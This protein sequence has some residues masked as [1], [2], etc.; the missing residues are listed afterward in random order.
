MIVH[1][2]SKQVQ[3][4]LIA[5][6]G[7]LLV[8]LD[9]G[10]FNKI[11]NYP[12]F[13]SEFNL[14]N[15]QLGT[16]VGTLLLGSIFGSLSSSKFAE[17]SEI[18]RKKSIIISSVIF[19]IGIILQ[20]MGALSFYVLVSGRFITGIALG[21]MKSVIPMYLSEVSNPNLRGRL[22]S[23]QQLAIT[24]G[25]LISYIAALY[26]EGSQLH[27]LADWQI[28][29]MCQLLPSS[30]LFVG[31]LSLPRSPRWLVMTG[32]KMEAK[33]ALSNL[34]GHSF[35]FEIEYMQLV[36][37]SLNGSEEVSYYMLW[38]KYRRQM[39][40]GVFVHFFQQMSG[41]NGL[42]YYSSRIYHTMLPEYADQL[43]MVQNVLK[44]VCTIPALFLV[45]KLGRRSLLLFGSLGC[46]ISLFVT[47]TAM[48]LP[49][50]YPGLAVFSIFAFVINFAYSMGPLPW[51]ISSEIF[52]SSI[53]SK[54]MSVCVTVN[55]L[56]NL[57]LSTFSPLLLEYLGPFTFYIFGFNCLAL[58]LWTL[59]VLPETKNLTL[60]EID[61]MM[62][63]KSKI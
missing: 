29:I 4:T 14:N 27:P 7:G 50:K 22:V 43:G 36:E 61:F 37:S 10:S 41:I 17:H 2:L 13:Q 8:G 16:L 15:L 47:A 1:P 12:S 63:R 11:Q 21:I 6:I 35:D 42:M 20:A 38:H 23:C 52:N 5:T 30:L 9:I 24:F 59:W 32:R 40:V 56:S 33:E 18:G 48:I 54:A 57:C 60:E 19:I 53:R 34:K 58:F 3:I 39:L 51:V 31:M 28:T 26:L 25:I 46:T 45:D 44:F 62:L 49:Q 55:L